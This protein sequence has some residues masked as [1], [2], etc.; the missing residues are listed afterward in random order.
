MPLYD[1]GIR[2][3]FFGRS[4]RTNQEKGGDN[5]ASIEEKVDVKHWRLVLTEKYSN[6]GSIVL[7][8]GPDS[9]NKILIDKLTV[10]FQCPAHPVATYQG[11]PS[12]LDDI[13]EVL[14]VRRGDDYSSWYNNCQHFVATFL[15]FLEAFANS[16]SGRCFSVVD[17]NRLTLIRRVNGSDGS[18]LSNNMNMFLAEGSGLAG[19][20]ATNAGG[21]ALIASTLAA[22]TVLVP[23]AGIM[24]WFGGMTTA[25]AAYAG[26]AAVAAPIAAGAAIGAGGF[27]AFALSKYAIWKDKTKFDDPRACGFP[28]KWS[29]DSNRSRRGRC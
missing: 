3:N 24:G 12:D 7:E 9:N 1:V 25:P 18:V 22:D 16:R 27:A 15:V 21:A 13:L 23:A 17:S 29:S 10:P 14:P 20:I 5:L 8:L 19:G 28:S 2:Y 11:Y 6:T 26:A 4:A